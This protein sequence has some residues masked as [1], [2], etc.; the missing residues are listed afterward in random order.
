MKFIS[1]KLVKSPK[2]GKKYILFEGDVV[3][4]KSASTVKTEREWVREDHPSF[5]RIQKLMG[6]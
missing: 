1:C 5:E 4:D 6:L 3:V 2:N